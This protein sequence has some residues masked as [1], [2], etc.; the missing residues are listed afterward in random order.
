MLF[1]ESIDSSVEQ[2]QPKSEAQQREEQIAA[3]VAPKD[4]VILSAE[5]Q[6]RNY[7]P[8]VCDIFDQKD[9]TVKIHASE[10]P[11]TREALT[12]KIQAI[13]PGYRPDEKKLD[14]NL[15]HVNEAR[16]A[17]AMVSYYNLMPEESRQLKR[18]GVL[19]SRSEHTL[20]AY[21]CHYAPEDSELN[22]FARSFLDTA[23]RANDE[24]NAAVDELNKSLRPELER[25]QDELEK[26]NL[27]KESFQKA[28]R[29]NL[30]KTMEIRRNERYAQAIK[31][32]KSPEEAKKDADASAAAVPE[33]EKQLHLLNRKNRIDAKIAARARERVTEKW[34]ADLQK[35]RSDLLRM[36]REHLIDHA[37]EFDRK[38]SRVIREGTLVQEWPSLGVALACYGES[39][40][41]GK[42]E[43][44]EGIISRIM[45]LKTQMSY[46]ANSSSGLLDLDALLKLGP[47]RINTI[48]SALIAD[49]IH[50]L[51]V[52]SYSST[53]VTIMDSY[54][55]EALQ[56]F[57]LQKTE[58]LSIRTPDGRLLESG[59]EALWNRLQ[60][61]KPVF[62][63]PREDPG[64]EPVLIQ[65][66]DRSGSAVS[67]T[68]PANADPAQLPDPPVS[69]AVRPN[70]F[71]SLLDSIISAIGKIF[72]ADWRIESCR[73]YD[74]ATGFDRA[75]AKTKQDLAK[76]TGK[77]R[78]DRIKDAFAEGK[79]REELQAIHE[80]TVSA[81]TK[82]EAKEAAEKAAYTSNME[83]IESAAPTQEALKDAALGQDYGQFHDTVRS[84]AEHMRSYAEPFGKVARAGQ[85]PALFA[86]YKTELSRQKAGV[87]ANDT[88]INA[89]KR[90]NQKNQAAELLPVRE[91]DPDYAAFRQDMLENVASS[92]TQ[93]QKLKKAVG[94][95]DLDEIV[96]QYRLIGGSRKPGEKSLEA[97]S[98]LANYKSNMAQIR[99]NVPAEK[100]DDPGYKEFSDALYAYIGKAPERAEQVSDFGEKKNFDRLY[101][102]F[103][104]E[105]QT[106]RG[107]RLGS[108]MEKLDQAIR[109]ELRANDDLKTILT[110]Q[111]DRIT[112]GLRPESDKDPAYADFRKALMNDVKRKPAVS[113]GAAVFADAGCMEDM[114]RL[115]QENSSNKSVGPNQ[116]VIEKTLN[117]MVRQYQPESF[118]AEQAQLAKAANAVE[119]AR[120]VG[121]E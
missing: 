74:D 25:E 72:G 88:A 32:G 119:T 100:S 37:A 115:Y 19:F 63:V 43:L 71:L 30:E 104:R 7:I 12:K 24:F 17:L 83:A 56:S 66:V 89:L 121:L 8:T 31:E 3:G 35:G 59:S 76:L 11:I 5:E 4:V 48:N 87:S 34:G 45:A 41:F 96:A 22:R 106:D 108:A 44:T 26:A 33:E 103:R 2:F 105:S 13:Q 21:A 60:S 78:L 91:N 111:M 75:L 51:D 82:K 6:F 109:A 68:D 58:E 90:L 40:N 18:L 79:S 65:P 20:L 118:Q 52:G 28:N 102:L 113:A 49:N 107:A 29:E 117:D 42:R 112:R 64:A 9:A 14:E 1:G 94:A 99:E 95:G 50:S 57:H 84:L 10:K 55:T 39:Q 36:S 93:L 114:F 54:F 116:T 15:L 86:E 53:A 16:T 62:A 120:S 85:F 38:L 47:G 97:M 70:G 92:S 98:N 23:R 27:A 61:G 77:N 110:G 69:D 73:K 80:N 46:H 101:Q 81:Y 67:F